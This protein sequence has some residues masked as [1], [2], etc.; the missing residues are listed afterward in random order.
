M[1]RDISVHLPLIEDIQQAYARTLLEGLHI[2]VPPTEKTKIVLALLV[3][4]GEHLRAV[5]ILIQEGL[6]TQALSICRTLV[7]VMALTSGIIHDEKILKLFQKKHLEGLR[8]KLTD[9][10]ML[11]IVGGLDEAIST[12]HS[13][14]TSA[15]SMDQLLGAFES[16]VFGE[17][18][19]LYYTGYRTLC[20]STHPNYLDLFEAV[21]SVD[22]KTGRVRTHSLDNA[23]GGLGLGLT[24]AIAA[25]M[26]VDAQNTGVQINPD[27]GE[28]LRL[29]LEKTLDLVAP[30]E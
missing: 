18:K 7:E 24:C 11:D 12:I 3:Q 2:E 26:S 6:P 4:A 16:R 25:L 5:K 22:N 19:K 17:N 28:S 21:Q 15:L 13:G 27:H 10:R 1:E 8:K 9:M 20:D 23:E 30:K 14:A 29:L